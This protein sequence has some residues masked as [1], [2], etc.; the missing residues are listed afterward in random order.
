VEA[1]VPVAMDASSMLHLL[2]LHWLLLHLLLLRLL[3]LL[4]LLLPAAP[5][6]ASAAPAALATTAAFAAAPSP[7]GGG[8]AAVPVLSVS[9]RVNHHLFTHLKL[10]GVAPVCVQ[11]QRCQHKHLSVC[12]DGHYTMQ[13]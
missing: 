2:L 9:L 5:P 1:D 11:E 4:L 8:A 6:A 13:L 7:P 3:H 12:E 10:V